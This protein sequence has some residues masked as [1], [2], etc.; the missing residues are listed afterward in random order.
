MVSLGEAGELSPNAS[1]MLR[2]ST[3]S[4][5]AQLEVASYHQAYLVAVVKPYRAT[6]ASMWIAALRDYA[7]IKID[8]ESLQDTSASALDSYSSLGKE[9][10]L[11]VS[12]ARDRKR[13]MLTLYSTTQTHGHRSYRLL[14]QPCKP[15]TRT[16]WLQWTEKNRHPTPLRPSTSLERNLRSSSTSSSGWY[17][18]PSHPIRPIRPTPRH[19]MHPYLPR[20]KLSRALSKP[21]MQGKRSSGNR[22]SSMNSSVYVIGLQ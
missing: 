1:A 8:S 14:L 16:F 15:M 18:N 5:W 12:I 13:I 21:S 7:T 22:L 4:A 19:D 6:L 11:P 3:L 10:L 17:M 9:V 2:I 20:C